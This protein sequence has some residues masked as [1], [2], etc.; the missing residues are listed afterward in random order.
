MADGLVETFTC[1]VVRYRARVLRKS[2]Q[3]SER[4]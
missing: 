3:Q 2:E 1:L 4:K